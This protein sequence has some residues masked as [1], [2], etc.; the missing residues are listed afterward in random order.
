MPQ[1]VDFAS[2]VDLPETFQQRLAAGNVAYTALGFL[3]ELRHDPVFHNHRIARRAPVKP[4]RFRVKIHAN[5]RGQF[6]G[7]ICP[8]AQARGRGPGGIA[9]L[10]H[11]MHV[12]D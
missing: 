10:A 1:P 7:R 4:E 8:H 6:A 3:I 12:V 5:G 2:A 9:P 11:D